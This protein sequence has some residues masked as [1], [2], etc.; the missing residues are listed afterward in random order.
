MASRGKGDQE[1]PIDPGALDDLLPLAIRLSAGLGDESEQE[2]AATLATALRDPT[3]EARL[4]RLLEDDGVSSEHQKE[5]L[6]MFAEWRRA[7]S[8]VEHA[9]EPPKPGSRGPQRRSSS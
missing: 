1:A 2:L 5:Y 8:A 3:F 6:R 9:H 4:K 7:A